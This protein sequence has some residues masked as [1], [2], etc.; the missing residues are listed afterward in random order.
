M[1]C[2]VIH[3]RCV[4]KKKKKK[5]MILYHSV[6]MALKSQYAGKTAQTNETK[7]HELL[8]ASTSLTYYVCSDGHAVSIQLHLALQHTSHH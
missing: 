3:Q 4:G 5:I 6:G 1:L 7:S 8:Y 2:Y